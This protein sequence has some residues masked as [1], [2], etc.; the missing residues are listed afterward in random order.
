MLPV[1]IVSLNDNDKVTSYQEAI[2]KFNLNWEVGLRPVHALV[3][4]EFGA[5]EVP[6]CKSVVRLD[7]GQPLSVV[8]GRYVPTQNNNA[9]VALL[10][11]TVVQKMGAKYSRG[12]TVGD[13]AKIF[14]QVELPETIRVKRSNDLIKQY[15]LYSNSFDGSTQIGLGNVGTRIVCLNTFMMALSEL[16]R[17]YRIRHTSSS[18]MRLKEVSEI[19]LQTLGYQKQLQIKVDW[20]ADQKFTD[21]QMDMA[22]RKAFGVKA[23]EKREDIA[24]RTLNNM[25]KV[26]ELF[27]AG[28]GLA[29]WR[30]TKWAAVNAFSEW[31]NHF[32]SIRNDSADKRTES[33]L[34]GSSAT[35]TTNSMEIVS[36]M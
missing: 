5:R 15:L 34:F 10:M 14:L 19:I 11:D 29:E 9:D 3:G 28:T 1:N 2:Q 20:L 31:S 8:G 4:G 21:L 17:E 24:T 13:S 25:D 27:E 16:G 7:N 32:R 6:D 22:I 35:F 12:G 30:G 26:R 36:D 23:E 18:E 33:V